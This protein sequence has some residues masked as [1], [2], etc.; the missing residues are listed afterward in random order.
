MRLVDVNVFTNARWVP[1]QD[2]GPQEHY[3]L[4][5]DTYTGD[6]DVRYKLHLNLTQGRYELWV[7]PDKDVDKIGV[8]YIQEAPTLSL[9]TDT[10]NWPSNWHVGAVVGAA[11][12][13]LVKEESDPSSLMIERD[14][15]VARILKDVRSQKVAEIKT[16]RDTGRSR[17]NRRFRLPRLY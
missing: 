17:S 11:V 15:A 6:Y 10:L 13:C 12:K 7:Y 3:Q 14:S 9:G 5:S 16:I 4:I 8:V 2:A 1:A